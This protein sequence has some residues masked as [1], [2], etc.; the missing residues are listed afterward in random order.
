MVASNQRQG[1][2][3]IEML[4]K[5]ALVVVLAVVFGCLLV[6]FTLIPGDR[7]EPVMGFESGAAGEEEDSSEAWNGFAA[8]LSMGEEEGGVKF[9]HSRIENRRREGGISFPTDLPISLEDSL[10]IVWRG[11]GKPSRVRIDLTL[12]FPEDAQ[13]S[14]MV[15]VPKEEWAETE[16]PLERFSSKSEE[17]P[18]ESVSGLLGKGNRLQQIAVVA[19]SPSRLEVDLKEIS[20]VQATSRWKAAKAILSAGGLLLLTILCVALLGRHSK[21]ART[22]QNSD[23][24][25]RSVFNAVNEGIL[26]LHDES[27]FVLDVNQKA[28]EIFGFGS[29]GFPDTDLE[30][31]VAGTIK[32]HPLAWIRRAIRGDDSGF[33]WRGRNK[34]GGELWLEI[35]LRH[36]IIAGEERLLAVVRDVG[37]QKEAEGDRVRLEQQLLHSQKLEAIGQLA[38]GVAHDFNNILTSISCST[39]LALK[40][41]EPRSLSA[42]GFRQISDLTHRATS[43]TRQLMA[44]SRQQALRPA[45]QSV[46]SLIEDALKMLTRLI[47]E[48]IE[49]VFRPEARPDAVRA[50][51]GQIEQ[52]LMNLAINARD[53]MK[54]GGRLV[55]ETSNVVVDSE[56]PADVEPG[57]YVRLSVTDNGVGMDEETRERLFEPF[58]TTKEVGK[59]TGLGLSTVYGIIR[60]HRGDILF[61]SR[62]GSGTTFSIFL[63]VVNEKVEGKADRADQSIPKGSETVLLVEDDPNTRE[64]VERVL[65]AQGYRVYT[66]ASAREAKQIFGEHGPTVDLLLT[67][68]IMPGEN[69]PELYRQL[70]TKRQELKVLFMSGYTARGCL[71]DEV[72]RPGLPFLPKPFGPPELATKIRQVFESGPVGRPLLG[73]PDEPSQLQM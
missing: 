44:F 37:E 23:S 25:Y 62:E 50:D 57:Q 30:G 13:L 73:S 47:G 42:A 1:N 32:K 5:T 20:W 60:Q 18:Q 10:R 4:L 43:L 12:E 16:I 31:I 8:D 19:K 54:D 70:L 68:I 9:L 24:F 22:L 71:Q 41:A 67:D 55:I 39:D 65:K 56:H 66:A 63:P 7:S 72:L 45:V 59:G 58:F 3:R 33:E 46:N 11:V 38:G 52:V 36:T 40:N 48:D 17:Q 14:T 29:E 26:V 53:A 51:S 49:L 34:A 15:V 2:Q 69:G 21:T 35:D 64:I 28:R 61:D 6:I 27:G